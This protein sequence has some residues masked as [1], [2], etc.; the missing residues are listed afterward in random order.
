MD[1]ENGGLIVKKKNLS[2]LI[3]SMVTVAGTIL[4]ISS[5]AEATDK[6]I[7]QQNKEIS[8]LKEKQ[9]DVVAQITSL[10]DEISS[11]FDEGITLNKQKTALMKESE[12]FK[13]DIA[14]LDVRINKRTEAIK[15]QGRNVQV[16]GQGTQILD[17]VL[18][19][20]SITDA[21]GRVQAISSIMTANNDLVKQQKEDKALV[22]SKKSAI[23][24]NLANVE[25]AEDQL[26]QEKE[27]LVAKQADLNVLKAEVES[28]TSGAES[29]KSKLLKE[30]QEALKA[31]LASEKKQKEEKQVKTPSK[32]EKQSAQSTNTS[33]K[34][35]EATT[36]T[37]ETTN[38]SK[39]S[40]PSQSVP[41]ENNNEN[42]QDSNQENNQEVTKPSETPDKPVTPPATSGDAT[43]QALNAL[44][45][46]NGLNPVSWDAGLAASASGRAATMQD[47]QVPSDHWN[48]G[49]EVIAFM[50]APGNSVIMAWY[51]ETNMQSPSGMGHRNWEMNPNMTRVGFGYAGDVIVGHSA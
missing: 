44:R 46:A 17:I 38:D 24:A 43:F 40:A 26:E 11:I 41:N 49:D 42:N 23:Q 16:N 33:E 20:E 50:F 12:Q 6:K 36:E 21:V 37:T 10:E 31:Q 3:V 15:K 18:N 32:S 35:T 22:E 7:E 28:E 27:N 30:Q 48:R 2:L 51:N 13:K 5:L 9:K 19:S 14:A 25:K 8:A 1:K 4:P 39:E 47:F 34:A 29:S 45:T